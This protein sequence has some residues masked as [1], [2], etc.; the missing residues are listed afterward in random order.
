MIVIGRSVV[1]P[2]LEDSAEPFF[3]EK[4]K[5]LDEMTSNQEVYAYQTINQLAF[6]VQFRVSIILACIDLFNSGIQFR[7]FKYAYCNNTFWETTPL[8]GF[9]LKQGKLP[10]F[11][12]RDIFKNGTKYGTECA[13]AMII[14][15]YK[16]LL[17]LYTEKTFNKLFADLLLYTWDYDKDL[18]LVTKNGG[19]LLPGDLVYFKNP[20]V[21]PATI[22]WQGENTIYLN[23]NL[24]YGHG[25]GVKTKENIIVTLNT[26]RFPGAFLSA[27]LSD[28]TTR[29]NSVE[30]SQYATKLQTT[31]KVVPIR[32]DAIIATI[33]HT[34]SVV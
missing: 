20:Q 14:V 30:M 2:L 24:F 9:R 22:E 5:I 19:E 6:D 25:V 8:G 1:L 21:N 29:I 34:T 31:I 4:Q 26:R 13:T 15:I 7:T 3:D 33:G 28:L 12:I 16:A 32:E 11:A 23:D 18:K 27:Y 17:D 10:A